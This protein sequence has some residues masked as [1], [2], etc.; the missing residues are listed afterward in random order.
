MHLKE[1]SS[2]SDKVPHSVVHDVDNAP[3]P[4]L[5]SVREI[6]SYAGSTKIGTSVVERCC[7]R[8]ADAELAEHRPRN[9]NSGMA[10]NDLDGIPAH[11]AGGR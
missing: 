9:E 10:S 11:R 5:S 4:A 8:A 7:R 1:G 3:V 6:R 2:R